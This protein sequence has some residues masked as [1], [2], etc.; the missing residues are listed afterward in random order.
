MTED[1][2]FKDSVLEI[3]LTDDVLTEDVLTEEAV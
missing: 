3:I 2:L 1:V